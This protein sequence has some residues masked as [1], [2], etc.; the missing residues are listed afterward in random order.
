MRF[1]ADES[2]DF[3]AV[4]ALRAAGHDVVAVSDISP[5]ATDAEVLTLA[6]RDGRTLLTED[7]DFGQLVFAGAGARTGVV[8]VRFRPKARPGLGKALTDLVARHGD[9]LRGRFT[10]LE[11]GKLVF[12]ARASVRRRMLSGCRHRPKRFRNGPERTRRSRAIPRRRVSVDR[13]FRPWRPDPPRTPQ[14]IFA[15]RST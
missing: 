2:C 13:D 4:R 8:L 6:A 15:L 10:V 3:A 11:P 1:L 14:P 9:N 5:S 7:K 12:P